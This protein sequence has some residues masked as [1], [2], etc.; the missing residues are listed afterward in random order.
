[1]DTCPVYLKSSQNRC[2]GEAF[3]LSFAQI[4]QAK[5]AHSTKV[6]WIKERN[7]SP[8]HISMLIKFRAQ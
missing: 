7:A 2:R 1:M 6:A 8:V 5:L 4:A 3:G